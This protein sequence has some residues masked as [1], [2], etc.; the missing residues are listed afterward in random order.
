[1]SPRG[2]CA[3]DVGHKATERNGMDPTEPEVE[4]EVEPSVKDRKLPETSVVNE[5]CPTSRMRQSFVFEGG[6]G[7][8]CQIAATRL[9]Q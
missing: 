8:E 6:S 7:Y 4:R 9:N 3:T 5:M 2:I 1:M